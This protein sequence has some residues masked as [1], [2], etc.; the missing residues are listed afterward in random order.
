[1]RVS[2]IRV[3]T[4]VERM[5]FTNLPVATISR[6]SDLRNTPVPDGLTRSNSIY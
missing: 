3:T 1:M 2:L 4:Q 5:H 6:N